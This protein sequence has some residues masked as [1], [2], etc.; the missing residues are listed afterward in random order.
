MERFRIRTEVLR[1]ECNMW[2]AEPAVKKDGLYHDG[3]NQLCVSH[4][5]KTF[6]VFAILE[7]AHECLK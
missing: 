7:R 3:I 4:V 6:F 2:T 1:N 5:L